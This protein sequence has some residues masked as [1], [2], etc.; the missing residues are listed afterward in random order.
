MVCI[1]TFLPLTFLF[2][3]FLFLAVKVLA[4]RVLALRG[5]IF[6][7]SCLWDVGSGVDFGVLIDRIR[8]L[9]LE[10]C[11]LR[12]LEYGGLWRWIQIVLLMLGHAG[13][14]R[15]RHVDCAMWA[16]LLGKLL[17]LRSRVIL[18]ERTRKF[19]CMKK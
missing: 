14:L 11:G 1:T 18:P 16:L 4:L 7:E 12:G 15:L 9:G 10:R 5:R 8:L 17:S 6:L 13:L 3:T 19:R 2:L